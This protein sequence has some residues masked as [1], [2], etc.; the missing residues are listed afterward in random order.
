MDPRMPSQNSE[1]NLVSRQLVCP[2]KPSPSGA[3]RTFFKT[4]LVAGCATILAPILL[5]FGFFGFLFFLASSLISTKMEEAG[6]VI[7]ALYDAGSSSA[8]IRERVLR[9]GTPGAGTITIVTIQGE[10]DG[11]GSTLNGSGALEYVAQQLRAAA[12][13][14]D[15]KAVVLQVDSPGGGLGVSD[16]L[17]HSVKA[18]RRSGKPVVAWAGGIMASGG[19]YIAV[20]AG[21]IIASPTATI[22]SI[23]V[24]IQHFNA[25]ELMRRLGIRADPV[26]SGSRKDI[27][28]PFREMTGEERTLLQ[29]Y[30]DV[31]HRRFVEIVAE[32]RKLGSEQVMTLA[33]GSIFTA[34]AALANGLVDRIGYIEDALAWAEDL[35]GSKDMRVV[36]YSRFP[37]LRGLLW[38]AG[39][40]AAEAILGQ[41]GA[42]SGA[43]ALW[44]GW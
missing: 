38:E 34:E 36:A 40:G 27:G 22:G 15:T 39:R 29:D 41:A 17:H 9:P 3:G 42:E 30:I 18:L 23:G 12:E 7:E 32:G 37:T 21:G 13:S 6:S 19:Y 33:D 24:M 16:Q 31:S 25:E 28:S 44:D 1:E 20:A 10:L 11:G 2:H 4:F 5:V 26:L 35:A 8:D 43:K 14:S